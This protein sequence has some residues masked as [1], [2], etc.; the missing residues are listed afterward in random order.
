LLE[1]YSRAH[2]IKEQFLIESVLLHHI[3]ALEELPTSIIIPPWNP[4]MT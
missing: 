2:G 1:W 4:A 3:Q